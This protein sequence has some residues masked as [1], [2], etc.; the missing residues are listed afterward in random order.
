MRYLLIL[1]AGF[2]SACAQTTPQW[3][4]RFGIDA[5]MVLARQVMHPEAARNTNPVDGMDGRS[6]RTAYERYQK[7]GPEQQQSTMTSGAK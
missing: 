3:D 6:A 2:L 1:L 5:R 7:A 4:A